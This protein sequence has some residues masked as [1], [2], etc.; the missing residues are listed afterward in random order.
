VAVVRARGNL[1]DVSQI[2]DGRAPRAGSA[3]DAPGAVVFARD[4]ELELIAPEPGVSGFELIGDSND[5]LII[6]AVGAR[7]ERSLVGELPEAHGRGIQPRRFWV[8]EAPLRRFSLRVGQTDGL[9]SIAEILPFP[10][11]RILI[12]VGS[13]S[14]HAALGKG[15][16]G[17]EIGV[18]GASYRWIDGTRASVRYAAPSHVAH[19]VTLFCWPHE[20]K[21]RPQRLRARIANRVVLDQELLPGPQEVRFEVPA[22]LAR[23]E[24]ELTFELGWALSP[25]SLGVAA[26]PRALSMGVDSIVVTW[27]D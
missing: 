19:T 3:W 16:S 13:A 23:G 26:D 12:D 14:A 2:S 17:D 8:N 1:G 27:E 9:I 22:A 24:L 5:V 7:G 4:F 18:E 10:S 25:A 20:V 6:E 15:W 11:Q 21:D